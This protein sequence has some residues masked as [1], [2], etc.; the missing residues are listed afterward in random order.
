MNPIFKMA[1]QQS[2]TLLGMDW[3]EN[4]S[5]TYAWSST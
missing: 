3:D 1:K 5:I 2:A 4:E